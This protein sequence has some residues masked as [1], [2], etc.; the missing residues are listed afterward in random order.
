MRCDHEGAI[1]CFCVIVACLRN[2]RLL[3]YCAHARART[4]ASMRQPH[5]KRD[6]KTKR[7]CERSR[8]E[9][10][11]F[12]D[13]QQNTKKSATRFNGRHARA[14]PTSARVRCTFAAATTAPARAPAA[15]APSRPPTRFAATANCFPI[16]NF[17]PSFFFC[18]SSAVA[19]RRCC[20]GDDNDGGGKGNANDGDDEDDDDDDDDD[21]EDGGGGGGESG[22]A[23]RVVV[24]RRPRHRA[25]RFHARAPLAVAFDGFLFSSFSSLS[26]QETTSGAKG[27]LSNADAKTRRSFRDI[28]GFG[29]SPIFWLQAAKLKCCRRPSRR[30]TTNKQY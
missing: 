8:I 23:V 28:D 16:A 18:R 30:T 2:A 22:V 24:T 4:R 6:A 15:R 11:K 5:S 21:D 14:A 27:A 25:K 20:C 10:Q 17:A 19:C 26:S 3:P 9:Q 7:Q 12:E 13:K 1:F 29:T